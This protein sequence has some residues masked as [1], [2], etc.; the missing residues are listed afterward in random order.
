MRR[1]L[2][3][4]A[5]VVLAGCGGLGGV[6]EGGGGPS[7]TAVTTL[8]PVPTDQPVAYPPG[9]R[10]SGVNATALA[11]AHERQFRGASYVWEF[12]A[13]EARPKPGL[14]AVYVGPSVV[15]ETADPR[16]YVIVRKQIT[17]RGGGVVASTDE[18]TTFAAGERVLARD[19][20]GSRSRNFT[21]DDTALGARLAGDLVARCLAVESASVELFA[22]GT[23]R[24]EGRGTLAVNGTDYGVTAYVD[25]NG[26]VRRFDAAYVRGGR[27]QFARYEFRLEERQVTPPRYA[28]NRTDSGA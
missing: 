3:L 1:G 17:E 8:A 25:E 27:V 23:A 5:V 15:A 4:V 10:E 18:I 16:R 20:N 21:A 22:N 6:G 24:I 11:V 13:R 2:V 28:R 7:S 9:V 26:I 14:G 19:G 12:D